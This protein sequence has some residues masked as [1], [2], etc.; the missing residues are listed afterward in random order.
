MMTWNQRIDREQSPDR[1]TRLYVGPV[2]AQAVE[3]LKGLSAEANGHLIWV[4]TEHIYVHPA[5]THLEIDLGGD[6]PLI[7]HLR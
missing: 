6:K 3:S 4:G 5:V 1:Y 2:T 7:L